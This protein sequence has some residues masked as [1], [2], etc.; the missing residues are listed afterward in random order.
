MKKAV[1]ILFVFSIILSGCSTISVVTDYDKDVNF[2]KFKTFNF[3]VPKEK[4]DTYPAIINPINQRRIENAIKEEMDV[5]GYTLSDKPDLWITYY[6]KVQNKVNYQ[7]T[8][9]GPSYYGPYY[10]GWYYGYSPSW[11][12]VDAI[13]YKEGTLVIDLVDAKANKLAWYGIGTGTLAENPERIEQKINEAVSK[14][15][16]KYPFLAGQSE[17]MKVDY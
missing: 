10:Y 11:T 13:H 12:T 15:F 7:T 14:I 6:V 17:A 4:N 2:G 5:R 1:I 8:T 9:Y 16:N 3:K